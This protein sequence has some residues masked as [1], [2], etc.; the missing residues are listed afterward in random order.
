MTTLLTFLR[1]RPWLT[2]SLLI[3]F[4]GVQTV[5]NSRFPYLGFWLG[6]VLIIAGVLVVLEGEYRKKRNQADRQG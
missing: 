1:R 6:A 5:I 2:P 4:L 3:I